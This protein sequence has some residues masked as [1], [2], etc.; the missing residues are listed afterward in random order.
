MND[1]RPL[2]IVE[3]LRSRFYTRRGVIGAVEDVSIT[4]DEGEAIGIVGESGSGK[5]VSALSILCL[6]PL[7]GRIEAGRVVLE[8]NGS[9]RASREGDAASPTDR[10]P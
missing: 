10:L 4:V 6:R 7:P 9:A 3:G 5:S 2:L 1:R 8:R